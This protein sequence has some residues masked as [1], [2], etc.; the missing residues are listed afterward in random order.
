MTLPYLYNWKSQNISI[1]H[2]TTLYQVSNIT[3]FGSIRLDTDNLP[4]RPTKQFL[5]DKLGSKAGHHSSEVP[6]S[7]SSNL[8]DYLG[9][10]VDEQ[11]VKYDEGWR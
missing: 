5:D 8:T 3:S 7:T 10:P 4:L 6:R 2:V 1:Y 11:F 9:I